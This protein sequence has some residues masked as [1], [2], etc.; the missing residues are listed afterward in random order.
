MQFLID[1][2][3]F[4]TERICS[5]CTTPMNLYHSQMSYMCPKKI[6][7]KKISIKSNS[8]FVGCKLPVHQILHLAYLWLCKTSPSSTETQSGLSRP[9]IS[10]FFSYFRELVASSPLPED[11]CIGGEGIVVELDECKIAKRKYNRGRR[12]K[13]VWILGHVRTQE[14]RTLFVPIEIRNAATLLPIIARHEQPGSVVRTDLWRAY[15]NIVLVWDY[16]ISQS[17]IREL[18]KSCDG[19]AYQHNRR[20]M[21]GLKICI[22][23]KKPHAGWHRMPHC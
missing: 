4:Y 10:N 22:S 17:T 3:V 1:R 14:K 5:S 11:G 7:R 23:P 18:C 15:S 19:R 8:F 20:Y 21:V 9:T 12:V 6:C 16:S 13:G 2:G